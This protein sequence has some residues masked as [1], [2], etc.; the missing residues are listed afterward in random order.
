MTIDPKLFKKY[1][2]KMPGEA[3]NRF[4]ESLAKQ[5]AKCRPG[6]TSFVGAYSRGRWFV[7]VGGAILALAV[8][9]FFLFSWK[10]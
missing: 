1:T 10:K 2:G 5:A 6:D 4:G 8:V 7:R 9:L 3:M